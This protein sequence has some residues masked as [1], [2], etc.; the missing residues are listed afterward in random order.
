VYAWPVCGVGLF[1]IVVC[2]SILAS[3]EWMFINLSSSEGSEIFRDD[4][5][6][7]LGFIV[8]GV[9]YLS[10]SGLCRRLQTP[11][12]RTIATI[13]NWLGSFHVLW[14]LRSLDSDEIS[15]DFKLI[16]RV[17]LPIASLLFVFGSVIRQMK[18]FFFAGLSGIAASVHKLTIEHLSKYFAWPFSL[19]VFGTLWMLISWFIPRRKTKLALKHRA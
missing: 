3:Q 17:I 4:E 2:L 18:S 13:L 9:I 5:V 8:N 14:S 6:I 10:L 16:Y 7:A 19:I 12:Q 15:S 1:M 11:L